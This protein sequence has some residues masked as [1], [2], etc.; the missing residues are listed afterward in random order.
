MKHAYTKHHP[1]DLRKGSTRAHGV[2]LS[3]IIRYMAVNRGLIKQNQED[4]DSKIDSVPQDEIGSDPVMVRVMVGF[5]WEQYLE[6]L[7]RRDGVDITRPPEMSWDGI[8]G[9]PDGIQFSGTE[10]VLHEIKSTSTKSS[11][12]V[13]D[14]HMWM[15]QAAGYM[16]IVSMVYGMRCN[17]CVFH[18]LYLNGNNDYSGPLYLPQTVELTD[19]E[20]EK[21]WDAALQVKPL[22]VPEGAQRM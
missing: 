18:P 2:H 14:K 7:W 11:Q 5:A 21:F 6:G 15:W 4:L 1:I 13:T 10:I 9:N 19:H 16:K 3:G 17:V 12:P 22:V 20:I 8:Y